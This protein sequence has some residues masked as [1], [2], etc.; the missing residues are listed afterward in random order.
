M[1]EF[2]KFPSAF[3]MRDASP[4]V[5]KL[6][7]YL[8][9]AGIEYKTTEESDPR[10]APKG[11]M[12]FIKD[13]DK[14]V[15]DSSIIITYLKDKYGDPL[16]KGLS[17]EQRAIGH[18]VKTMLEERTYWVLVNDRWMNPK[19]QPIIRDTWFG[20]IPGFIRGFIFGK[21]IKDMKKGMEGHGIGKH[22]DEEV[23]E[24]GFSDIKAFENILGGKLYLLGD[25]PSEY[26]AFPY[27]LLSNF[28]A[29]PF[30]NVISDYI[31]KSK[32]LS[33]YIA[34]VEKKAFG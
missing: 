27:A 8:R 31:G 19:N 18:A 2:F 15:A 20:M 22:S 12:P 4:F 23:F 29:K 24:F 33:A 6:E 7:T 16:G 10:K 25:N 11:K 26:D 9:L 32:T 3:G 13:G 30:P 5:L 1:I 34:R 28:M 14:T 21:I 17:A